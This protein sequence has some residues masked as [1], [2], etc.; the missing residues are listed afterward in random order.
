[1]C[2]LSPNPLSFSDEWGIKKLPSLRRT[3]SGLQDL[4]NIVFV[5]GRHTQPVEKPSSVSISWLKIKS[6]PAIRKRQWRYD[7]TSRRAIRFYSSW[8]SN[9]RSLRKVPL[10]SFGRKIKRSS[11]ERTAKRSVEV[12]NTFFFF[13]NEIFISWYIFISLQTTR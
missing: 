7:V 1:M 8:S 10:G 4:E 2:K 12:P 9:V 13:I 3:P 6:I 11:G 5:R